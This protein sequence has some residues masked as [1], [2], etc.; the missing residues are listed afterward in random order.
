MNQKNQLKDLIKRLHLGEDQ[1]EIKKDFKKNFGHVS[2]SEIAKLEAELISEGLEVEEVQRLCNIHADVF[3][4][5]ISDLHSLDQVDQEKGH[6][7]HIFRKENV[8]LVEYLRNSFEPLFEKYKEDFSEEVKIDLLAEVHEL[9][10][11]DRHYS[12]K[13]NL[14]FPFLEKAGVNGP[15]QVMWGKDDE[16]RALLKEA[17]K[18]DK[19]ALVEK[20]D[21]ALEE[22]KSMIT[23]ENDILSPLLLKNI[24]AF[25][26]ITIARASATI[27][28]AFNGGIEGASPSDAMNWIE[29][30]K[31]AGIDKSEEL[32]EEIK[33][34]EGET[35]YFPSGAINYKDLVTMLNSYPQDITFID[36]EDKVAYFSEGKDPVFARTR[37]IIGRD[38]RNCHPPKAIPIVEQLL[39]DFKS[40]AKDEEIRVIAKGN[41]VLLV[42]YFAVRDEE[43]NYIGTLETTEEISKILDIVNEVKNS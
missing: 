24:R 38:V 11:I 6:P 2:S 1:V 28:Y 30:Q 34:M 31:G 40:G 21:L 5:S 7:L 3:Q 4:G 10:K 14:F 41:K 37:T 16:V 25:E 18:L 9:S 29:K 22:I 35:I 20:I 32:L 26:W 36:R 33:V 43:K 42:R 17:K 12:R 27:G 13:E 15:P 19:E 23:K 39:K 8:G